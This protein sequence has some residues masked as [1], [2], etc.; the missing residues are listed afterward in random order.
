MVQFEIDEGMLRAIELKLKNMKK[1]AP[2]VL[3]MAVNDT[4]RKTKTLIS[5]EVRKE[6]IVKAGDINQATKAK[7]ATK[8][9][10]TATLM[11]IS[12]VLPIYKYFKA[13]GG[14]LGKEEYYNP[15]LKRKMVGK[16]GTAASVKTKK[17]SALQ[18]V[19][20]KQSGEKTSLKAFIATMSSGHTGVFQ[21]QEGSKRGTKGEI[22]ELFGPSVPNMVYGQDG[23][24]GAYPRIEPESH[25]YLMKRLNHHI[26]RVLVSKK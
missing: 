20:L 8:S 2:N 9:K 23:S 15:T 25:K 26:D 5:K 11:Y 14:K 6:Y 3:K 13:K 10:P 12:P 4:A 17:S 18:K 7:L 1:Q 22:K 24:R 16:G 21:R 19:E